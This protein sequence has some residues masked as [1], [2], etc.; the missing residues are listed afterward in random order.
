MFAEVGVFAAASTPFGH[1]SDF[2]GHRP[3]LQQW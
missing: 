2:V 1:R 3:T